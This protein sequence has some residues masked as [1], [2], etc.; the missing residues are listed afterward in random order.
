[1]PL[2]AQAIIGADE[3]A[4]LF[5]QDCPS[6]FVT[7]SSWEKVC[8]NAGSSRGM[9][10][11]VEDAAHDANDQRGRGSWAKYSITFWNV[12]EYVSP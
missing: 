9:L 10:V 2:Q 1:M 3:V 5:K 12:S 7:D 8:W 6:R 11:A 4:L